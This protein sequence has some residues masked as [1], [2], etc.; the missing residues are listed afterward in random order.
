MVVVTSLNSKN[1]SH[2]LPLMKLVMD[3]A[4]GLQMKIYSLGTSTAIYEGKRFL[5][6]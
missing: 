3:F 6:S 1:A 5:L 2:S 4:D